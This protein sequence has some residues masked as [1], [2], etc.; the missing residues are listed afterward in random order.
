[1]LLK[2]MNLPCHIIHI[3]V[4][5]AEPHIIYLVGTRMSQ[6]VLQN[7]AGPVLQVYKRVKEKKS[8]NVGAEKRKGCS[9]NSRT[10]VKSCP[11]SDL[12]LEQKVS[13]EEGSL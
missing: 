11:G 3:S 4:T 2:T 5:L 7:D 9:V 1:M 13:A 12:D 6:T 8:V 10:V